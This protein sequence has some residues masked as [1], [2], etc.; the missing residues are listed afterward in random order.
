MTPRVTAILVT[1]LLAASLCNC[2]K[3]Q[4]NTHM[5]I[6][7]DVSDSIE[8]AA[9]EQAF[10]AVDRLIAERHRGDKIAI[11]PITG[12]AEAETSGRVIR[13]EV[14][15]VR[16]AYDN[17]LRQFR[18]KLKKSLNELK[19][20]ALANPGAHTDILGA[21]TLAQQEFKFNTGGH[22]K[23]LII[24]SDFLQDDTQLNFLKD[25]RLATKAAAQDMAMQLAKARE[26]DL[27]G[28]PVYLGLLRSKDYK[29]L[30]RG[31]RDAVQKFWLE[32]FV[33]SGAETQWVID[34]TGLF[35]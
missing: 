29:K 1:L 12:D 19:A 32:Y 11:I 28:M 25:K 24:L 17:D 16:Q 23:S 35:Q 27:R 10:A 21:I 20:S 22:T 7:I 8:P 33:A 30:D 18:N 6:L 13:F 15:K 4:V 5:V 31:R 9:E 2:G 26:V 34:G 14:P 3:Q